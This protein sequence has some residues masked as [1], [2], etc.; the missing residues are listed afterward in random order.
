MNAFQRSEPIVLYIHQQPL[1]RRLFYLQ[2]L[3]QITLFT[4]PVISRRMPLFPSPY[5]LIF[6]NHQ[7]FQPNRSTSVNLSRSYTHFRPKPIPKTICEP[8][9]S[10]NIYA[11]AVYSSTKR[12]C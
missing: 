10:I 1:E 9:R 11:R 4:L 3:M 6:V 12:L 7:S 2:L 5:H 8:C